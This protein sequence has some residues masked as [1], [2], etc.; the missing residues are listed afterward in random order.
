[1]EV[2]QGPNVGCS[3]KGGKETSQTNSSSGHTAVLLEL[4][5]SSQ[6]PFPYSLI[7][8]RNGPHTENTAPLLLHGSDHIENKSRDGYISSPLAR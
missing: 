3:A 2:G 5:D 1:M 4:R 8:S 7:S 6:F